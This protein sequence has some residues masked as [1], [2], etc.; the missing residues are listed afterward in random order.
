MA[1]QLWIIPG[2]IA[3]PLLP[4]LT[5]SPKRDPA[6]AA[7]VARHAILWT[8]AACLIVFLLAGVA[9]ELLYSSAFLSAA[10]AVRRAGQ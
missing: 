4:H 1:E 6:L 5:N 8:G 2:A 3:T 7:V 10:V 9:V